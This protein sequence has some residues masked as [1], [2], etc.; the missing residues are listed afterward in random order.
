MLPNIRAGLI[1]GLLLTFAAA[2]TEYVITNI[3]LTGQYQ[4]LKIYMYRLMNTNGNAASVLTIIFFLFLG[5][6]AL[7][8]IKLVSNQKRAKKE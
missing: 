8:L 5:V 2:F 6:I 7:I 1:V 4:T 3:F